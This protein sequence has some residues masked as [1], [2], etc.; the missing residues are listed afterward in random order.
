MFVVVD[1]IETVLRMRADIREKSLPAFKGLLWLFTGTPEFYE[2]P[3]G[4]AGLTP[5]HQRI[6]F[7]QTGNFVNL[8][9]PQLELTPF[10]KQKLFDVSLRL[11][12][13]Y[14]CSDQQRLFTHVSDDFIDTLVDKITDGFG[15]KLEIVL[16]Q[17]L[18]EFSVVIKPLPITF[19]SNSKTFPQ[20][21]S[22][23]P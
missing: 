4:V 12:K 1:E 2:S 16:R 5:L 19:V 20:M 11:R 15:G 8:R 21:I 3:K 13:I 17:F 10:D 22:T 23:K 14:P 6:Y 7:R 18:R 9:Q